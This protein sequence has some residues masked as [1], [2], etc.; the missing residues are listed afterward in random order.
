MSASKSSSS[1]ERRSSEST[2][3]SRLER[4]Y[5]DDED[6]EDFDDYDYDDEE[7]ESSIINK[8]FHNSN[9]ISRSSGS[10]DARRYI[11]NISIGKDLSTEKDT[12][13]Q[14]ARTPKSTSSPEADI[15]AAR[16]VR[17]KLLAIIW[18]VTKS[19]IKLN[20]G[21]YEKRHPFSFPIYARLEWEL[22]NSLCK[23][24]MASMIVSADLHDELME[25][26]NEGRANHIVHRLLHCSY[27][28][29]YFN[30][31]RKAFEEDM[32]IETRKEFTYNEHALETLARSKR[33]NPGHQDVLLYATK[34]MH[35][36]IPRLEN[37]NSALLKTK[38]QFHARDSTVQGI[39]LR[40]LF[41]PLMMTSVPNDKNAGPSYSNLPTDIRKMVMN[42]L[43]PDLYKAMRLVD[44]FHSAASNMKPTH[45][46][47]L[48]LK[49]LFDGL[50]R[51]RMGLCPSSD[52]YENNPYSLIW[53]K[54]FINDVKVYVNELVTYAKMMINK[55]GTPAALGSLY[56]ENWIAA[57]IPIDG[58]YIEDFF[59]KFTRSMRVFLKEKG[60]IK[61]TT[62]IWN[63][64]HTG[65]NKWCAY[66]LVLP[67]DYH[68]ALDFLE[69]LEGY[70][71]DSKE[72]LDN[73]KVEFLVARDAVS[74]SA[75]A[76][77]SAS[78]SASS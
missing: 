19:V 31:A 44:K 59:D 21:D 53:Y 65:L 50:L 12:S 69:Y 17:N 64:A 15:T 75:S 72:T 76:S 63:S 52:P 57:C 56:V 32:V 67:K 5:F 55:Q 25:R 39:F 58:N 71:I 48:K 68:L 66:G 46:P 27:N 24:F 2:Q 51:L 70:L 61:I 16:K 26:S 62:K 23:R 54:W 6:D 9:G 3:P 41:R 33:E 43:P 36:K 78:T 1:K 37:F 18:A 49:K 13:G 38:S 28:T 74:S 30:M 11:D 4:T 14:P 60:P 35:Q 45:A 7:I 20:R 8:K 10:V 77:A 34:H 73:Y 40:W 29:E 42:K 47:M 22:A